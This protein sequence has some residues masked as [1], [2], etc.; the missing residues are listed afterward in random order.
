[1]LNKKVSVYVLVSCEYLIKYMFMLT[2]KIVS[3]N[4][5]FFAT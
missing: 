3:K 2:N 4:V 5:L 1:M